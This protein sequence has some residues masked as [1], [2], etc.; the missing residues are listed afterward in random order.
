ML[1]VVLG[2]VLINN[3]V[4]SMNGYLWHIPGFLLISGY[5]GIK[6]S[7]QKIIKLIATAYMCYW[8]TIPL[9]TWTGSGMLFL[10]HGGWFLPFYCVL[11]IISPL[12]NAALSNAKDHQSICIVTVV[13]VCVGWIPSF[14]TNAHVGMLAIPGM[15]G[16][17]VLLMIATYVFGSLL[18]KY[19]IANRQSAIHWLLLFIAGISSCVGMGM[20]VPSACHYLSP[21]SVATATFGLM[22]FVA[23]PKLPNPIN[24]IIN[25]ISPSMFSVYLL[26]ECCIRQ[27]QYLS[28]RQIADAILQTCVLFCGCLAIDL[29][30]RLITHETLKLT[31]SILDS[32]NLI[33][34]IK[35]RI[36]R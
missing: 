28:N 18:R 20:F 9:R 15:Q 31:S 17:G 2:H 25:F 29:I 33:R 21:I 26:H 5:F 13:L 7:F 35:N 6:F 27:Y 1:A 4:C 19:E 16:S 3:N 22:F 10:P 23:M 24:K 30:R 36:K 11:M 12:L 14:T 34:E 8:L 32:S